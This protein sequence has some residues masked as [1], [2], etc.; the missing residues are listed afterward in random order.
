MWSFFV[1]LTSTSY[2]LYLIL[3][4]LTSMNLYQPMEHQYSNKYPMFTNNK[5]SE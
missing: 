1:W 3:K 5:T 2:L 4:I